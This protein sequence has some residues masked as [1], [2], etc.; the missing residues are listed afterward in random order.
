MPRTEGPGNRN[1]VLRLGTSSLLSAALLLIPSI[2][3][4]ECVGQTGKDVMAQ[5]S[6]DLV[7]SGTVVSITPIEQYDRYRAT[8]EVDR[9]W[10][11]SVPKRFDLYVAA[12]EE[13]IQ[14]FQVGQW[15]VVTATRIRDRRTR[16]AFALGSSSTVAFKAPIC[17]DALSSEIRRQL[18]PG[19]P[20]K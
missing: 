15:S 14:R 16:Q 17:S 12:M 5:K 19:Y 2:G 18:G 11:G 9:V 4:A 7:F 1:V 20:P 10:K 8:F 3:R 13:G 6:V